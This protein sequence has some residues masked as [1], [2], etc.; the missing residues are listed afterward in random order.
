[1]KALARWLAQG[2]AAGILLPLLLIKLALAWA[3]PM[4]GD[5]AYFV[6]WGRH[7]DYGYYDHP[8]MAGWLT[9]LQLLVSDHR[10][11]IRMPGLV[12]EL[13]IAAGLYGLLVRTDAMRARWLTL[14]FLVMP[15]S[16]LNVFT[17]TDTGCILFAALAFFAAARGVQ[18]GRMRWAVLAGIAL[19]LA[20]LSKYFAVF[21]GI[22]L[23]LF[24]CVVRP[25]YWRQGV[26]L[27]LVAIPFG[28]LNLHWNLTHCWSN[29]LFNLVNRNQEAGGIHAGTLLTY[30]GMM[31]YVLLPPVLF[32]LRAARHEPSAPDALLPVLTLARTLALTGFSGFLLLSLSKDIGLHWVLWFL[33]MVLVLLWPLPVARLQRITTQVAAISLVHVLV[34]GIVLAVPVSAWR[35]SMQWNLLAL[36]EAPVIL[37]EARQA[38]A[39]RHG[40]AWAASLPLATQGYN[41]ASVLAYQIAA[42]V[43]VLGEG[44]KYARQ[45]D[46]WTDFRAL[47]GKDVLLL[48][49]R[50]KEAATV[51]P[52]F[53]TSE[54]MD[55]R[56]GGQ[57]F[58]FLIGHGFRY[59]YYRDTVLTKVRE[60]FY[61]FPD[62]LPTCTCAFTARY[63]PP[64]DQLTPA[65]PPV[66]PQ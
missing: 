45:D 35:G 30:L 64:P 57:D 48:L 31:I 21:L 13:V 8:P 43:M 51:M 2:S 1:M 12:S 34:L 50:E 61:A 40:A 42:P 27:V 23:V 26:V 14:L 20:F 58:H 46:S 66:L 62:W 53:A 16:L 9:W 18:T 10:V 54:R 19:G 25:R 41:S 28:L 60:R 17:L 4:T 15:L 52:W 7:L 32:G 36:R 56:H 38:L 47:D 29:L 5:E 6:L 37:S 3:L 39:A 11:W 55:I 33:P 49:K 65:Q 22:G 24:H 44:S 59:D 63:F